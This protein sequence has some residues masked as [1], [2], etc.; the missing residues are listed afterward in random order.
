MVLHFEVIVSQ[1]QCSQASQSWSTTPAAADV[2]STTLF[3][4]TS[5]R[6]LLRGRGLEP[7]EL[8]ISL[9]SGG[10]CSSFSWY[11]EEDGLC[12]EGR[13]AK[14]QLSHGW[15]TRHWFSSA[16]CVP[17]KRDFDAWAEIML[18][19]LSDGRLGSSPEAV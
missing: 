10:T 13:S 2:T 4:S 3:L 9:Y 12:L 6:L 19:E 15:L 14:T 5:N 11:T 8:E 17:G 18:V 1:D 7:P 16:A